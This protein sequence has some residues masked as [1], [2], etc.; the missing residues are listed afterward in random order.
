[1]YWQERNFDKSQSVSDCQAACNL[2]AN[3]N[4][5]DGFAAIAEVLLAKAK[6]QQKRP[7]VRNVLW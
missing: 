6:S 7:H 2:L 1:M 5:E 4:R 3:Q